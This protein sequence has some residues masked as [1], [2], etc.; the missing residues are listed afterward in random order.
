LGRKTLF[1]RDFPRVGLTKVLAYWLSAATPRM[2][3][4]RDDEL[5]AAS[6]PTKEKEPNP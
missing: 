2:I 3:G 4:H 6:E 1:F 5:V